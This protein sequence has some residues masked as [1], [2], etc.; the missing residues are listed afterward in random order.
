M[1]VGILVVLSHCV[2]EA[3]HEHR[4]RWTNSDPTIL[5]HTSCTS[6][7]LSEMFDDPLP[8]D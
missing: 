2:H 4:S 8:I 5:S 1:M 3:K 6:T 7:L